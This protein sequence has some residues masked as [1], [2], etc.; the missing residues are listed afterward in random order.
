MTPT[1]IKGFVSCRLALIYELVKNLLY[2]LTGFNKATWT[3]EFVSCYLTPLIISTCYQPLVSFF[4]NQ[5]LLILLL[6]FDRVLGDYALATNTDVKLN[7]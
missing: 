2:F 6:I 5:D 1:P 4:L 3:L 7:S